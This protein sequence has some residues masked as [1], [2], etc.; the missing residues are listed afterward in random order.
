MGDL[1][2]DKGPLIERRLTEA[3]LPGEFYVQHGEVCGSRVVD[4]AGIPREIFSEEFGSRV[5][6]FE[7]SRQTIVWT[8]GRRC[9]RPCIAIKASVM[10]YHGWKEVFL[11]K[12]SV[13]NR[14]SDFDSEH[15]M[16]LFAVKQ[17][18]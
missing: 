18:P 7:L 11:G 10:E 8:S 15:V 12:E 3:D 4:E 1:P 5:E 13:Y 16:R 17:A 9:G 6:W 2:A 14:Y